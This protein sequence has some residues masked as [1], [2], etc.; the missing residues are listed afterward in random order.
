[1]KRWNPGHRV[2]NCQMRKVSK[3]IAEKES[4]LDLR[5]RKL[6]TFWH[7]KYRFLYPCEDI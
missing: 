6:H 2:D 7:I 5:K 1:M 4:F 3:E